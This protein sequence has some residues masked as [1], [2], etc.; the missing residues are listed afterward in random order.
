MRIVRPKLLLGKFLGE[1]FEDSER[2]PDPLVTV[3]KDRNLAGR[4]VLQ[5]LFA[6]TRLIK[7]NDL[8]LEGYPRH[9]HGNP[10]PKRP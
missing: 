4:R 8:F 2:F 5:D 3:H 7:R 9:F 6:A 1:I 10:G